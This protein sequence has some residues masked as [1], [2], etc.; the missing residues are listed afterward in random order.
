MNEMSELE[1][2]ARKC[3]DLVICDVK[4]CELRGD[5]WK[6]YMGNYLKCPIYLDYLHADRQSKRHQD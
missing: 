3:E 2:I 1:K 5:Y 4:K 6:C